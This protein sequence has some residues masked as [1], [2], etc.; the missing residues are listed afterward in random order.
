MPSLMKHFRRPGGHP[1]GTVPRSKCSFKMASSGG[2]GGTLEMVL[3]LPHS[4]T[5]KWNWIVEGT[6][7]NGQGIFSVFEPFEWSSREC[8]T[9]S[10]NYYLKYKSCRSYFINTL[11]LPE[12]NNRVSFLYCWFQNLNYF[13]K[14]YLNIWKVTY[15]TIP[16]F[17]NDFNPE[18][19]SFCC[20]LIARFLLTSHF[21][22]PTKVSDNLCM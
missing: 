7:I 12:K 9:A 22:C 13:L 19:T 18:T 11:N 20:C 4:Y 2:L 21:F 8:N 10:N 3:A 6:T 17:I 1:L 14:P 5:Q 15:F 16:E